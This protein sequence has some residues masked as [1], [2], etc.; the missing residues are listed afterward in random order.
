MEL[1]FAFVPSVRYDDGDV[2]DVE[3]GS[4]DVE[5]TENGQGASNADHVETAAE[6]DHEP[7]R[8]DGC[9]RNVVN[10]CPEAVSH[11]PCAHRSK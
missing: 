7:N 5:N 9:V 3:S 11:Q 1:D 6:D 10:L 2:A 8:I 4:R